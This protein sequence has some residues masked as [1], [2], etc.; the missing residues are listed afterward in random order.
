MDNDT[1][2]RILDASEVLFSEFGFSGV[3][4]QQI[5][6]AVD[7]RHA[8]LYYYA[9][10]GKEDLYIK[11]TERSFRRHGEGLTNA[12][13]EAGADFRDQ[14]HAVA[15]WFAVHPPIDL[16]RIVRSDMPAINPVDAE[17]LTELSLEMLRVPIAAIIRNAIRKGLVHVNDPDFAAMGLVG[18]LQSVHNIPQRFIPD[19]DARVAATISAANMLLDGWL[20]R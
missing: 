2:Q 1:Y 6:K 4:L 11:V 18:L 14:V 8:S 16:G 7:M 20:M 13:I 19:R 9:P 15:Y 10:K 5:A 17:R 12:I 3:T